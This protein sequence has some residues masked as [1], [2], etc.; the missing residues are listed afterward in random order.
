V[1][2]ASSACPVPEC[3][4]A[5]STDWASQQAVCCVF[6]NADATAL[7]VLLQATSKH[8][9]DLHVH[10]HALLNQRGTGWIRGVSIC[11]LLACHAD[12]RKQLMLRVQCMWCS[13]N[14]HSS[15]TLR[16]MDIACR[17][18]LV[19]LLQLSLRQAGC[20]A[21]SCSLQNCC[22][23]CSGSFSVVNA[24]EVA[25]S[26]SLQDLQAPE[27]SAAAVHNFEVCAD[28]CPLWGS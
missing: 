5:T 14:K 13:C 3:D 28:S 19:A 8:C 2:A 26:G 16:S 11:C 12:V 27:A 7:Y 10:Y 15:L 6:L 18:V 17:P 1:K 23:D 24:A 25:P 9:A 22:C 4:Y 21:N 20:C